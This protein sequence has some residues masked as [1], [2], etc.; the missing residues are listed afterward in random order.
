M[1]LCLFVLRMVQE[2]DLGFAC[3][4]AIDYLLRWYASPDRYVLSLGV[5]MDAPS[6]CVSHHR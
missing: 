3:M 1:T 6:L 2:M 5:S 4:F